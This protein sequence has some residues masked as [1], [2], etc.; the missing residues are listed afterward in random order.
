M[1]EKRKP[2]RPPLDAADRSVGIS[3]KLPAKALETAA[4]LARAERITLPEWI[5]R[6]LRNASE[7]GPK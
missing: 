1:S 2:G 5:R 7:R 3:I 6:T 4:T